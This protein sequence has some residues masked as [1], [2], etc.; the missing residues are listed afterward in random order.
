[1]ATFAKPKYMRVAEFM[2]STCC[3]A[4]VWIDPKAPAFNGELGVTNR[5]CSECACY[6]RRH[7]LYRH[8]PDALRLRQ[9]Y[10]DA[11]FR[12]SYYAWKARKG[13]SAGLGNDPITGQPK[14]RA[15]AAHL[16]RAVE[17]DVNKLKARRWLEIAARMRTNLSPE[18]RPRLG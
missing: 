4:P 1:M 12:A 11:R 13:T 7:Q 9:E 10:Q 3:D 5:C 2:F 8:N 15:Q 18:L 14:P 17:R 16:F 6:L